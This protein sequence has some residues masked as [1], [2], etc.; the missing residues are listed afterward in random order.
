MCKTCKKACNCALW[1][2]VLLYIVLTEY[3][4][5]LNLPVGQLWEL[6]CEEPK[7]KEHWPLDPPILP[8]LRV[9]HEPQNPSGQNVYNWPFGSFFW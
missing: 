8:R 2:K 4:D 3:T 6:V 5:I 1:I 9:S 7:D